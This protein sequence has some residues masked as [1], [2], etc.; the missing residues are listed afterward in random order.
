MSFY[1]AEFVP[2]HENG[3]K[4]I[5]LQLSHSVRLPNKTPA[6]TFLNQHSAFRN[7]T[8]TPNTVEGK[9]K[10]KTSYSKLRATEGEMWGGASR[11]AFWTC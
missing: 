3:R 7:N 2:G 11:V 4:S 1:A 6:S 9:D 10:S 5:F 8:R